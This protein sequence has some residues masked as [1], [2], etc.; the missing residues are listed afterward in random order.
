MYQ[1]AHAVCELM[2]RSNELT[3]LCGYAARRRS[4]PYA[5]MPVYGYAADALL[6]GAGDA[7][8]AVDAASWRTL[9]TDEVRMMGM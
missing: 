2:R 7:V 4:K 5:S 8:D 3:S 9:E 6:L 1:S